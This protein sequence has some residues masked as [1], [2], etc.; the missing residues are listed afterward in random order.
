[1]MSLARRVFTEY[2]TL[3]V[4]IGSDMTPKAGE[5]H[6]A[7]AIDNF[8][9]L[10]DVKVLLSL[11]CLMPFLNAIHCLIKFSQSRD[12]FICDFLKVVKVCHTELA[13]K[14][15]DAA[16]AFKKEDFNDYHEILE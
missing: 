5:K 9:I 13:Y 12:V 3:I 10:V 2:C 15:I 4:K 14:Y 6:P 11:M 7:G 8:D 1:M 16:T